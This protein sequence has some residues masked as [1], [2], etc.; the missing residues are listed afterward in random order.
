MF[1]T[2]MPPV[3]VVGMIIGYVIPRCD[4]LAYGPFHGERCLRNPY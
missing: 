2:Y 3:F 1:Q 4:S